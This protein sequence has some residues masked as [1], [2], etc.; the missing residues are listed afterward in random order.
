MKQDIVIA[1]VKAHYDRD[2]GRFRQLAIQ[3]ATQ[4][5]GDAV[6]E[7]LLKQTQR[8]TELPQEAR[9]LVSVAPAGELRDLVLPVDTEALLSEIAREVRHAAALALKG[10]QPRTRLLFTGPPGNGKTSSAA[11]LATSLGK[12]AYVVSLSAL[13]QS[14][15]GASAANITK[16]FKLLHAGHCVVLDE[17]DAV[18]GARGGGG[19]A[20]DRERALTVN[21]LLTEL[22]ACQGGLL[23][24]TTNRPDILD[25]ALVRRFD[26][27]VEFPAPTGKQLRALH[28]RL[29]D[30]YAIHPT[31]VS[32][33]S[34]MS[35]D[36]LA[37]AVRREAR[38]VT[39]RELEQLAAAAVPAE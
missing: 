20:A 13:V 9:G 19:D 8:L 10:L 7:Q 16:L 11:A 31:T 27:V 35:F 26:E 18:G 30:R 21:V 32:I 23:I 14:Y 17:V 33:E 24:A 1:L 38:A 34:S 2:D 25:S 29:C 6:K 5:K 12:A 28:G 22:D 3:A 36:A 39:L 4:C 15:M 37:K